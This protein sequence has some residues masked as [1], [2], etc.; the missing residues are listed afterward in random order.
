MSMDPNKLIFYDSDDRARIPT[1]TGEYTVPVRPNSAPLPSTP[2][3]SNSAQDSINASGHLDSSGHLDASGN[4]VKKLLSKVSSSFKSWSNLSNLDRPSRR[5]SRTGDSLSSNTFN[6]SVTGTVDEQRIYRALREAVQN[7][8]GIDAVEVWILERGPTRGL[9]LVQPEGDCGFYVSPDFVPRS[10]EAQDALER[11]IDKGRDDYVYPNPLLLGT[12]LAGTIFNEVTTNVNDYNGNKTEKGNENRKKSKPT[13]ARDSKTDANT[14]SSD[15]RTRSSSNDPLNLSRSSRKGVNIRQRGLGAM[16]TTAYGT[17]PATSV[18]LG[19][20]LGRSPSMA[21]FKSMTN[22]HAD[23]RSLRRVYSLTPEDKDGLRWRDIRSVT[24]DPYQPTFL[25][26]GLMETAGFVQCAGIHFD[27][28]GTKGIVLFL[29]GSGGKGGV[30]GGGSG[31]GMEARMMN[32]RLNAVDNVAYMRAAAN[33]IGGA[34]ALTNHRLRLSTRLKQ[35]KENPLQKNMSTL[36]ESNSQILLTNIQAWLGKCGGGDLQ[37]PPPMA[38]DEVALTFV[39]V[40]VTIHILIVVSEWMKQHYQEGF[41]IPPFGALL[42]L[43]FGLTMAPPAQPRNVIFGQLTATIIAML[44]TYIS[45]DYMSKMFR[46]SLATATA[47]S[48]KVALG[49]PH[50]PAGAS[51]LIVS[52]G[53]FSWFVIVPILLSNMI[54]I[55]AST[56]INNVS[57]K[58]QYPTYYH[59]GLSKVLDYFLDF[60][61]MTEKNR[62]RFRST[63][64]ASESLSNSNH[65][66][67]SLSSDTLSRRDRASSHQLDISNGSSR[68]FRGSNSIGSNAFSISE[69]PEFAPPPLLVPRRQIFGGIDTYQSSGKGES[70]RLLDEESLNYIKNNSVD[71]STKTDDSKNFAVAI[72]GDEEANDLCFDLVNE[73]PATKKRVEPDSDSFVPNLFIEN[74]LVTIDNEGLD[75]TTAPKRS[76]LPNADLNV[77]HTDQ[78]DESGQ[79]SSGIN[80]SNQKEPSRSPSLANMEYDWRYNTSMFMVSPTL[81]GSRETEDSFDQDDMLS[82]ASS[83][84]E[85]M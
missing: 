16:N 34:V 1:F 70:T 62:K 24:V 9:R 38:L 15:G 6:G 59:M 43:Q 25:R 44:F 76:F 52:G 63:S 46:M 17:Y 12:G 64:L 54:A 72:T 3:Y 4:S 56:L 18:T 65:S 51:A 84:L 26:L 39:G 36:A 61:P 22:L 78:M 71:N 85:S 67:P 10:E 13:K 81:G 74:E 40:Y 14:I 19:S 35:Q 33:F 82:Y 23:F 77:S 21:S 28:Q 50:P 8:D 73:L 68:S 47:I 2:S 45:E 31:D 49:V 58:R 75:G 41:L 37:P 30:L 53:G 42:T 80:E 5:N 7:A 29:T 66:R 83:E 55:V 79:I 27:I 32:R 69:E 60:L 20:S 48:A 57:D 11:V